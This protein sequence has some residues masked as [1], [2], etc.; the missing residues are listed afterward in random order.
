LTFN[1]YDDG[2]ENHEYTM[3]LLDWYDCLNGIE[4]A[5]EN[6]AIGEVDNDVRLR[7]IAKLEQAILEAY[8]TVPLYNNF[9]A[10]LLSYKVEFITKDYNTFM[11]YGGLRY[12]KYNYTDAEWAAV[13]DSFD[14][15]N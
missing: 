14:Y 9:T 11:A 15:K 8:Y 5:K 2:D 4:G 3:A 6:W 1:P 13:K 12:L 7:I 10:Q